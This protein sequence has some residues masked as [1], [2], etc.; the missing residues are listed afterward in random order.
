MMEIIRVAFLPTN[1]IYT[2]LLIVVLIYWLT[3]FLG[4]LDLEFM[5]FDLDMDADLDLDVDVDLDVEVDA[6]IDTDAE[7]GGSSSWFLQGLSFFHLGKVPFMVFF[8]FL[9]LSM[10]AIALL[11]YDFLGES[12][13]SIGLWIL[14]P[15][16]F[17]SL[18]ITKLTTWPLVPVFKTLNKEAKHYKELVG[19]IATLK[20]DAY[21]NKRSQAEVDADHHFLLNVKN[22]G[23]DVLKK[24]SRVLL[25]EFRVEKDEFLITPFDIG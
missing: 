17:V 4:L 15:N 11:V 18:F 22:E 2:F 19:K 3:V 14:L 1:V 23:E 9:T 7:I 8:S 5:E 10:W 13:P 24:G 12:I 25:V 20:L 6:D 21:P 16:L